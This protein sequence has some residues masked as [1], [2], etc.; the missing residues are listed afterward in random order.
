LLLLV[1]QHIAPRAAI[2]HLLT[3]AGWLLLWGIWCA[4][5]V[6]LYC[7]PRAEGQPG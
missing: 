4:R 7:Q 2:G 3:A 1:K 6:P 5:F